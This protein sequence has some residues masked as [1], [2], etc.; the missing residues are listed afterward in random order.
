M[1]KRILTFLTLLVAFFGLIGLT[2][3]NYAVINAAGNDA[4]VEYD[5]NVAISNIPSTA[6]L[7]FP[8][9]YESVYGNTI[10]WSVEEN[11]YIKYDDVAHWMVVS[12]SL[13]EDGS[14]TITVIVTNGNTTVTKTVTVTVPKGFTS[15]PTY[16]VTYDLDGGSLEKEN[17]TSYKLG[18]PSIT[19]NNP[20]KT[21]YVFK[22]WF[23][24][25]NNK[26]E[27]ILVGSMKN[28]TLKAEWEAKAIQKIEI[29]TNPTKTEYESLDKI[30]LT[31]IVVIAHY[32]DGTKETIP[33]NSLT[34]KEKVEYGEQEVE[35]SYKVGEQTF[36]ATYPVQVKQKEF[37]VTFNDKTVTYNGEEHKLE[38]VESLPSCIKVT[39]TNNTYTT[40]NEEGYEATVSF[41][42]NTSDEGYEYYSKHYKLPESK[43][44]VLKINKANIDLSKVTFES[45]SE[46]YN[47]TEYKLELQGT[48]PAGITGVTYEK[49]TLTNAGEITA[50]ATLSYDETNYNA[51]EKLIFTA[52]LT[53]EQQPIT[54]NVSEKTISLSEINN[55]VWTYENIKDGIS[56]TPEYYLGE[57]KVEAA[58]LVAGKTYT[59]KFKVES[60]NYVVTLN[61]T[62]LTVSE[63]KVTFKV[64]GTYTYNGS[65]QTLEV[66]AYDKDDQEIKGTIKY[67]GQS[68]YSQTNA[69]TY[70]VTVSLE[71][72][73]YGN[74]SA[75]VEFVIAAKKATLKVVATTS[76]YGATP[77]LE[78][79]KEGVLPAD[80]DSLAIN[81][82]TEGVNV[83]EYAVKLNYTANA[84]YDITVDE[85][86]KH[87]ITPK[88]A[89]LTVT[90]TSSVYG[91]DFELKY[92]QEGILNETDLEG[93]KVTLTKAKGDDAGSYEVSLT[94]TENA[95]YTI[96]VVK[97]THTINPKELT[98]N[99]V[100]ISVLGSD[101]NAQ[102]VTTLTPS[103]KV[104]YKGEEIT[105]YTLSY[106]YADETTKVGTATVTIKLNG[107]YAGDLTATFEVTGYGKAWEIAEELDAYYAE[108]LTGTLYNVPALE[109]E[110][111][112]ENIK[113]NWVS[114][115]TALSIS[116]WGVV[117][118]T[119]PEDK[120]VTV[121]LTASISYGTTSYAVLAYEFT[122]P[123]KVAVDF[124]E[125]TNGYTFESVEP[126]KE[127]NYTLEGEVLIAE[128]DITILQGETGI[129]KPE[130]GV[131]VRLLIPEE[132]RDN[133]SAL[134]VYHINGT[135]K[136][137]IENVRKDGNYLVFTA[138]SFSPYIIAYSVPTVAKTESDIYA[139]LKAGKTEITLASD[140]SVDTLLIDG[141]LIDGKTVTI[142]LG[143]Y[144]LMASDKDLDGSAYGVYAING[145]VVTL[146]A[147]ETGGIDAGSGANWNIPLRA[148]KGSTINVYGGNYYTGPNSG[149]SGNSGMFVSDTSTINIYGGKFETEKDYLG[150]YYLF[151]IKMDDKATAKINVYAGTFVNANPESSN[152]KTNLVQAGS[153]VT[154]TTDEQ[155]KKVY[156][157]TQE[158]Y[159]VTFNY[160][161]NKSESKEYHY[162]DTVEVPADLSKTADAQY[163]YTFAGWDKVIAVVTGN[164][165]YTAKYTETL[166]KYKVQF[167]NGETLL[168]EYEL[169]YGATPNYD[170]ETPT[171][172]ADAQYTYTF[173]AWDKEIVVVTGNATYT[174]TYTETLN[175]Y[176][177]QFYNGETLLEEYELEYGAT[178][179]YDGETPTK[180][181]D[182]QY[183]YT[184]ADWDKE[185]ASVTAD[186]T[187]TATYT[188]TVNKYTIK[189]V[190]EDGTVLQESE[191]AYGATPAYNGATPTKEADEQYAYSF[192]GWDPEITAVTGE[193]T[194]TALF[195]STP[196]PS[197][198]EGEIGTKEVTA[199]LT[200]D[201]KAKRT[202]FNTSHQVWVENGITLTNN[203][204]SSTTNVADYAEPARFYK[205]S[206]IVVVVVG[207]I[208]EISFTCNTKD[209][210]TALAASITGATAN[211]QIVTIT[212]DGTSSSYTIDSLTGGQ[213]R[214][215][216]V[217]VTYM[218]SNSD[219]GGDNNQNIGTI[220]QEYTFN[221]Y[222]AGTQYASNEKHELDEVV[223]VTTT[224]CHFTSEL[225]IYSSTTNNGYAII[226]VTG[227]E[228]ITGFAFN[229]GYK[230]DTLNVYGST[231]GTDWFLI[232]AVSITSTSYKDYTIEISSDLEYTFLKLDVNGSNQVRVKSM[233]LTYTYIKTNE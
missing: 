188:S 31:G 182:A 26:V 17:P 184:F 187:Y 230:V 36:T 224:D 30:D 222:T 118:V 81:L 9:T 88:S 61:D 226:N 45:L 180:T 193:A 83:G 46:V 138:T 110:F 194:Y 215:D 4:S 126:S 7:S 165:T 66:K 64:E 47:G 220:T 78:Y 136:E 94:Y 210:A 144:K 218:K 105:T 23:D 152:V 63:E 135:T 68:S 124:G 174:A 190:N 6:I 92:T 177:V 162:G 114:S 84:N 183:T 113:V 93:L 158:T 109:V 37:T 216:S 154:L 69:G 108:K 87:T 10:T 155:G 120:D 101:Y 176:K 146:I 128:Y 14:A 156:T 97:G 171:K 167:Y 147:N 169:E 91:D 76:V 153:T 24:E 203:K 140:V 202:E 103:V 164:A 107:N 225:R 142:N 148:S 42:W 185:L 40:A 149:N 137:K 133:P 72:T 27:T 15:A 166:N 1:K 104:M 125:N 112:D 115:S 19:L 217:T 50:T 207:N 186:A 49:N 170:G 232:Q 80:L 213:V 54:L 16:E 157:V 5:A 160:G 12:R 75:E 181:A 198:P 201:D 52:T 119:H 29:E 2:T 175:K 39:Y 179:N 211:G 35:V 161:D 116:E 70:K 206:E 3:N 200:F 127:G 44:A 60:Q 123:A 197:E 55:I 159:T 73:Q 212:L 139:M 209:Y 95:N 196:I 143:S 59:V 100:T 121:K 38:K 77:A 111:D 99:D 58:K 231:N 233:T 48:L 172:T 18:D 89:T 41:E 65:S 199:T 21:G 130:G 122:I 195:D 178:P 204:G 33:T 74:V 117:T 227:A 223:T 205:S 163:T 25:N 191:V 28:Y 51:P 98:N 214:V 20:T 90:N 67:A 11:D 192:K 85:T 151:N 129:S 173:A 145:A 219:E 32:N 168:E 102:N 82:S 131:T 229:A 13:T 43:T 22:G 208:K 141:K 57:Q 132:Y 189:F 86:A 71:G 34:T 221:G 53:I 8:V 228:A 62:T 56:V 79:T 106:A 134:K 96:T 150:F